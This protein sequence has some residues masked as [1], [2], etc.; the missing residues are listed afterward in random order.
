MIFK[1][2]KSNKKSNKNFGYN[3]RKVFENLKINFKGTKIKLG[4]MSMNKLAS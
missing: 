2:F 4:L 1:S 3:N